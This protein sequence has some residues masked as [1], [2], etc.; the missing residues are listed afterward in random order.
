M[1][2]THLSPEL[3]TETKAALMS[4]AFVSSLIKIKQE[5]FGYPEFLLLIQCR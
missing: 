3:Y 4:A 2:Y 5:E 1:L